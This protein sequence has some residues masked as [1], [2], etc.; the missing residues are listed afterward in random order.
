MKMARPIKWNDSLPTNE[1]VMRIKIIKTS[2]ISLSKNPGCCWYPDIIKRR[3]MMER[4]LAKKLNL[5]KY[6]TM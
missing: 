4:E 5:R 6:L 2:E 1:C 3:I